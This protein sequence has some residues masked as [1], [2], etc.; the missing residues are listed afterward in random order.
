MCRLISSFQSFVKIFALVC[1]T[2]C[3]IIEDDLQ[4]S[5]HR[6]WACANS[7]KDGKNTTKFFFF[8]RR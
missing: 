4:L 6:K 7:N 3:V 5:P 8:F 2:G 1:G